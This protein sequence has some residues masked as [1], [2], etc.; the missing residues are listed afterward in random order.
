MLEIKTTS[1]SN[2][3]QASPKVSSS[4]KMGRKSSWKEVNALLKNSMSFANIN[5]DFTFGSSPPKKDRSEKSPSKHHLTDSDNEDTFNS[6]KAV[7][8]LSSIDW[9]YS[10]DVSVLTSRSV[11][12][13]ASKVSSDNFNFEKDTSFGMGGGVAFRNPHRADSFDDS[14]IPKVDTVED[15]DEEEEVEVLVGENKKRLVKVITPEPVT[16]DQPATM[17]MDDEESIVLRSRGNWIGGES[18]STNK[19][20]ML[21]SDMEVS[22]LVCLFGFDLIVFA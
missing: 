19:L 1:D 20:A 3:K 18:L 7:E 2:I 12:T 4:P 11:D 10:S 16:T 6:I 21:L 22:P 13:Y 5:A 8:S 15:E 17:P 9:K 14:D